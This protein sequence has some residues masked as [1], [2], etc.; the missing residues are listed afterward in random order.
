MARR[1][2]QFMD[3][4]HLSSQNTFLDY[5][6][7]MQANNISGAVS[8]LE[9]NP[10]VENQITNAGN[11][12]ILF[13]EVEA[14]EL[15]PKK[16]IDDYLDELNS[17]FNEMVS[18]T[19]IVG[20]WNAN[21]QY[22]SHNLVYY[23]NKGY[24]VYSVTEPPVG[25]LPTDTNYW[26]EY[27]IKGLKGYGGFTNLN[28]LGVWSNTITYNPQDVVVYQNKMWMANAQNTN[29][30]PNLNHY[31]WSLIMVP[32]VENKAAIQKTAP[33]G[34]GTG[35]F[36]FKITQGDDIIQTSWATRTPESVP[37]FSSGSFIL[38]DNIYV[39]GGQNAALVVTNTN[40]AYDMTTNTWSTKANMPVAKDGFAAFAISGIGYC[41][42]GLG[43][44]GLPTNDCYSYNPATN[45]WTKIADF[46]F[47]VA[48]LGS[49]AVKGNNAYL[50][51]ILTPTGISGDIYKFDAN[52]TTWTKVTTMP[53]PRF[54]SSVSIVDN[55]LY[56]IGGGE[57]VEI[58]YGD[59]QIYDLST[60]TWSTGVS[61]P[62]PRMATGTFVHNDDVFVIGGLD[63]IQ[64]ST[65]LNQVYNT[66]TN[67]WRNDTSMTYSRNSLTS[68][69]T[70]KKGYAIGGINI[71][72]S[73]IAG[74]M[75]EYSF[76]QEVSTFE[77]VIDTSLNTTATKAISIPMVQGG[78]YNY[79]IDWGDGTTSV[80][81]NT[82]NSSEATH[83]YTTDGKYTIKLMGSLDL[84]QFTGTIA[85]CLKEV[86][87]CELALSTLNAMFE[88][89]SNLS[90]I[91]DGIFN[92]SLN[93][94]SANS[95]FK[96]CSSLKTIPVG[97][98]DNNSQINQFSSTFMNSGITNIPNGLFNSNNK[99]VSFYRTFYNC[100]GLTAIPARLFDS[101]PLVTTFEECFRDCVYVTTIPDNLLVNNPVV[102]NYRSM[103]RGCFRI[104]KI[105]ANL[106]GTACSSATKFERM[107]E[108]VS[109][110]TDDTIPV[111]LFK[112][113]VNAENYS[114]VFN[115]ATVTTIPD[116][117]FNGKNAVW[118]SAF[119]I[120]NITTL[121][122]NSL[123]GLNITSNM[124]MSKYNLKT[125]GNDAFWAN[126]TLNIPSN[127]TQ[128]LDGCYNLTSV[129]NIN[130][131]GVPSDISLIDMFMGC[132]KLTNVGGFFYKG[133]I[134]SLGNTIS[135]MDSPLTH[136]SLINISKSL[137]T[138]PLDDIKELLL[139]SDNLAKL[140]TVEKLEIIN[141][142]WDLPGFSVNI[143][144]EIAQELILALYGNS[145]MDT[146][147]YQ[148]TSLYFYIRLYSKETAQ[149][150]GYY[151]VDKQK[152]YAYEY[153]DIPQAEYY[154]QTTNDI[155]AE[156]PVTNEYWLAKGLENDTT[157]TILKTKL[158]ELN[159]QNVQN[160]TLG[161]I[162][163]TLPIANTSI[164]NV[165]DLSAS[166]K[167]FS[168]VK[169]IIINAEGN[170]KVVNM[171][172]MFEDCS[173]LSNITLVKFNT[174]NCKDMS[175]LFRNCHQISDWSF[176]NELKTGNV[177]NMSYMFANFSSSLVSFP[178]IDMTS[179]TNTS[180][181]FRR[182]R[183]T[184]IPG[185]IIGQN[186]ENA[187][188][189]FYWCSDLKDLP[190]D[191]TTVFG[192]NNKLK[193][194][195]SMFR[196]CSSLKSIG[197][198][199]VFKYVEDATGIGDWVIDDKKLNNQIFRYCPNITN[200]SHICGT[201]EALG[202][203][204]NNKGIPLGL[205][206]HCPK[207]TNISY[208]FSGCKSLAVV[209]PGV[210]HCQVLFANNLELTDISYLF[211]NATIDGFLT[212]NPNNSGYILFP[213]TKIENASYLF[214]NCTMTSVTGN[215]NIPFVYKSKVLKNISHIFSN[216]TCFR[217]LN[218]MFTGNYS[219]ANMS[220]Y[221]PALTDCSYM[222]SGDTELIGT[223]NNLVTALNKITTL[224]N[225][226]KVFENCSKLSDYSNI[227]SDW[228]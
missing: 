153:Q 98:F 65:N 134:P 181:M 140:S 208:A 171:A 151:A 152:G 50:G 212:E 126:D 186:I 191:Y 184:S 193:N 149:N 38:G 45:A 180:Y 78:N 34:Y 109:L 183:I 32:G 199:N 217:D 104:H 148:E 120:M 130:L 87:K 225:H 44:N 75:E 219:W 226:E 30:A 200:M 53:I 194:V 119:P 76:Q 215:E 2:L 124:F 136:E 224:E 165:Q 19:K 22:Y 129:G 113:A 197:V 144:S 106:V 211:N 99:T 12:N 84:L 66:T 147:M 145:S 90:Y 48:Y 16:D 6:N 92:K 94:T 1:F 21:T 77:M 141:K 70:Q 135:F 74:Y 118:T 25:T 195:S 218:N 172:S 111:G 7:A 176:V 46:P 86:T 131:M 108:G 206:Y 85:T 64:Y 143:T 40:E 101:N 185:N 209:T 3:D 201:C 14:R 157:G 15:R 36:W 88:N 33:E 96:G 115:T 81:I 203:D 189:M 221:C 11:V 29:Y 216:Q 159:N 107:F 95:C 138:N 37:R 174:S 123:N 62:N 125:V 204:E 170:S 5:Y 26:I 83:T 49:V 23:Q 100:R 192:H 173:V 57:I 137:K 168:Y 121:G 132:N 39:V 103:F 214:N 196:L 97:L 227:P 10:S 146:Q 58:P 42:G 63:E 142:H 110:E 61:M 223:G 80:Q 79:W 105:P 162:S 122:N 20:T 27:D 133:N 167:G 222:F 150:M 72:Q 155:S 117:C 160:I 55:K 13:N 169:E 41:I 73:N 182:A 127:P 59:N 89:C 158:A 91:V 161:R 35:D 166:F 60:N 82:Y 207:V 31:P 18:N 228:K 220:T 210:I 198:H 139:G 51:A 213:G 28:Y 9:N 163:E 69:Y 4:M 114:Y 205:F 17:I 47:V 202:S 68:Q 188:R 67:T 178:R 187:E 102:D 56:F 116:N 154:I 175:Y 164:D 179:V 156:V 24:F 52:G 177:L 93:V 112:S 8:I 190:A 128:L 43:A 54:A 71:A